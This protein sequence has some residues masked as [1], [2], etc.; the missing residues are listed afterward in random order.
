MNAGWFQGRQLQCN[1][2][3]S[4]GRMSLAPHNPSATDV[5]AEMLEKAAS[6]LVL[7]RDTLQIIVGAGPSIESSSIGVH[8]ARTGERNASRTRLFPTCPRLA[9]T[10]SP[11]RP[12]GSGSI[13]EEGDVAAHH[14]DQMHLFRG[15]SNFPQA[16]SGEWGCWNVLIVKRCAP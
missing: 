14:I 9:T 5:N 12:G 16:I 6:L 4:S 1:D 11:H 7:R 13:S 2:T 8:G 10:F 3:V 15:C